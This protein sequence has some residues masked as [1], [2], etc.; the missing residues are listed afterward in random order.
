MW[1]MTPSRM[2]KLQIWIWMQLWRP[3]V[4]S[5]A[6][7]MMGSPVKSQKSCDK[8]S[9]ALVKE[10]VQLGCV[11]QDGPQRKSI[12]QEVGQLGPDHAVKFSKTTMRHAKIRERKCPS[13]GVVQKSEFCGL[14]NSRI[15]RNMKPWSRSDA[16]AEKHGTCQRMSMNSKKEEKD[17]F[18]S[19]AE[20]SAMP[21]PSSKKTEEREFAIDSGASMHMLSKKDP[22]SGK[23]ETL[24]RSRNTIT[25]VTANGEV[26]TNEGAYV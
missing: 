22:G 9:V 25:A 21:A 12:L 11:S 5:D 1:F 15:E 17:S 8:G 3:F 7:M 16:P 19:P 4:F 20:A 13:Q 2:P 24:R 18:C 6:L 23:L 10:N 14:Q 26:Q